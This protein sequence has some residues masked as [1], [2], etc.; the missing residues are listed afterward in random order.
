MTEHRL[1]GVVGVVLAGGQ[2][3]R[4]GGGDKSLLEINGVPLI[5]R[6][7]ERL[8][9][10]LDQVIINANGDPDRFAAQNR[11]VAA[12]SADGIE[13]FAGPLAGVL[14]GM[15]WAIANVPNARFVLTAAADTP[16]F[17][18]NLPQKLLAR[19][20]DND[21]IV[22]AKSNGRIHPVFGLWPVALAGALR[23]FLIAGDTRKVLAFVD[24]HALITVDFDIPTHLEGIADP[25]FNINT[26]DD[27]ET[28]RNA[29]SLRPKIFGVTGWKNTGKTTLVASLV[30]HFTA[31]GKRVSTL[32]HS[33][34]AFEIDREG[35]DSWQ[36]REAG[37]AQVLIA[38]DTRWALMSETGDEETPD[39][40]NL[41]E[42]LS[43]CDLVLVEGFKAE[44]FPKI[45]TISGEATPIHANNNTVVATASKASSAHV[46]L[47]HFDLDDIDGIARFIEQHLSGESDV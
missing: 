6:S 39:F 22:M 13:A 11:P 4:M 10:S 7:I 21:S 23:A 8:G 14:A 5:S 12:D 28:A 44:D 18:A 36:H 40:A 32:K 25:F 30:K 35:T 17:P 33:H 41:V 9:Q 38:A 46:A 37:A 29:R 27:L 19:S 24:Q 2:A 43:P 42:K 3:R 31:Q 20:S 1:S 16:F 45:E 26:P 15:E 47:P 34:H